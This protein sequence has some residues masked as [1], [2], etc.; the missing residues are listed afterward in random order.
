VKYTALALKKL[1]G[2]DAER[3][4]KDVKKWAV[5]TGS[6]KILS[7]LAEYNG[8]QP[9]R[10]KE[11]H[12]ILKEYGNL[13]GASLPFILERIVSKSKL[14]KGDM[15]LMLGYGWGFSASAAMLEST[16]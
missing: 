8:I 9:E 12:E 1:L 11:S 2:N 3:I 15:V 7:A 14:A 10:I 5:H 13:A 4:V 16:K 6:E